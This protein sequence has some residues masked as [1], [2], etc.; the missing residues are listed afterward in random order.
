VNW[1]VSQVG[2]GVRWSKA[3]RE[4]VI[5]PMMQ[6]YTAVCCRVSYH[7]NYI[8]FYIP[9]VHCSSTYPVS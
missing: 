7:R 1:A 3:A 4:T 9:V 8:S 5:Q 6:L 2:Y